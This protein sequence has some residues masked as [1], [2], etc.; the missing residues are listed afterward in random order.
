[1]K[2]L[3]LT[4]EVSPWVKVGGIGDVLG[5]LPQELAGLGHD[6]RVI[7]PLYGCVEKDDE[8]KAHPDLLTI[9]LDSRKMQCK[10]WETR[11][12]R[13]AV[14]AYFIEYKEF[15]AR[16]EVYTG[17]S[18]DLPD[19]DRRFTFLCRAGL[20]LCQ[21][22]GWIPDV[23]HCHDWT[24]CMASVFLD[25]TDRNGPL[26]S[27]AT[28]LTIHNLQH[29]GISNFSILE[30]AQLPPDSMLTS[31]LESEGKVNLLREGIIHSSK[32]TTVSPTYA[33]EIMEPELGCGLDHVLKSRSD[34]LMGVLNG[35]DTDSWNPNIDEYLPARF[36]KERM[37]GKTACRAALQKTFGL[38]A[39]NDQPIFAVVSRLYNQKGIDL[40]RTIIPRLIAEQSLQIVILGIG[41]NELEAALQR[42][43]ERYSERIGVHIGF[44]DALAHLVFAGSDFLVMPSRFEPCGLSQMYAMT[45]GCPPVARATGGLIDTI[46]PYAESADDGKG[47]GL[48]FDQSTEEALYKAISRACSIFRDHP[49]EYRKLQINGMEKNFSWQ[50]SAHTYEEIYQQAID[51]RRSEIGSDL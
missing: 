39:V 31:G 1:M 30:F 17:P 33:S 5:A 6:V 12:P 8:W 42:Q 27:T 45:Y 32:V 7:C 46:E 47:T 25:T 21:C 16:P 38:E 41:E 43:A 36:G 15:F 13:N 23:I 44:N 11:L 51:S 10:V 49:L 24:T 14:R 40:L 4:P 9:S 3:M 48:L 18:G 50:H 28:V 35:I 22:L 34:N 20:D 2:V 37:Q 26:K 29:Q 19:N